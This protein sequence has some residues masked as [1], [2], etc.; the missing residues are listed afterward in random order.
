MFKALSNLF[1]SD[2]GLQKIVEQINALEPE[3]G[4][5]TS[6]KLQETSD[7]LK[8]KIRQITDLEE[9]KK[10][11]DENLPRVFALVR[12]TAQRTL[13][14][15]HFDVQLMGGITLHQGKIAEMRTGE[16]KT[17]AATLP[18]Y[19]N[20]LAG[21][22]VHVVTVNDYLAKRDAVWMGQIYNTLG[23]TVAC[24]VHEGALIYDPQYSGNPNT[25]KK[26]KAQVPDQPLREGSLIDKERDTTGSFLVQTEYL[27]P[28]SRNEAY[29][30][31]ITYGTNH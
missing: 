26:N 29:Q 28:I 22:G 6:D 23:L 30:A 1:K 25:V 31:D 24:L 14:Q 17:L 27:R 7:E 4:G 12:E 10:A 20:A 18:A 19:L 9:Q 11:L 15:R 13:H 21:K 2:S 5:L 3:I 8:N 16:G